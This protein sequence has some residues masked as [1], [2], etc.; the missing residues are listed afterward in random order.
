MGTID[1]PI[2]GVTVYSRVWDVDDPSDQLHANDQDIWN[3]QQVD[4]N[5][6]GPDNRPTGSESV[7]SS[8]KSTDEYGQAGV[9]FTVSMRPG[10]NYRAAA[11]CFE[12]I[13]ECPNPQ[14]DQADAG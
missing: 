2:A 10:N 11:S 6:T 5:M 8:Y 4:G 7:W 1:P 12:D 14:V 13:F 9:T 3:I